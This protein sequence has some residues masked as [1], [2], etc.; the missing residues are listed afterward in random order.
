MIGFATKCTVHTHLERTKRMNIKSFI[1]QMVDPMNAL[2]RHLLTLAIAETLG[3][4]YGTR[5][6]AYATIAKA[7]TMVLEKVPISH[8]QYAVAMVT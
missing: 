7:T 3:L 4:P 6:N 8:V 5:K 2:L 1:A